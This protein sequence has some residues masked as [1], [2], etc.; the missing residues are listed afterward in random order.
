MGVLHFH[1][2]AI[3]NKDGDDKKVFKHDLLLKVEEVNP[4]N[5]SIHLKR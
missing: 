4:C 2:K 5:T 1:M 3:Q